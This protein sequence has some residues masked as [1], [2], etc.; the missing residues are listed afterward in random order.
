MER[1]HLIFPQ[2]K[3]MKAF[4]TKDYSEDKQLG[5]WQEIMSDVY[6]SLEIKRSQTR[7][8]RGKIRKYDIGPVSITTFDADEQRVFRTKPRIARDPEDAYVFVMPVRKDLYFNHNGRSGFVKPGGHVLVSTSDFYELSCPDGFVNWTVKIPGEELRQRNPCVDDYT[9]CRFPIDLP[10][11][12]FARQQVRSLAVTFGNAG[13]RNSAGLARNLIDTIALV[14]TTEMGSGDGAT[15]SQYLIRGRIMS[16]IRN[17]IGEFDLSP[18]M[19]AEANGISVSYL[20][21]LFRT[22]GMTVGEYIMA[23]RLQAAYERLAATSSRQTTVAE[24]AFSVGFRN[25][26]HF[27]RVFR[28]NYGVSPTSVRNSPF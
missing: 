19:I 15:K 26:S 4:S 11:S 17:N 28:E 24:V 18:R 27:S 9:G 14:V 12:H 13:P 10:M 16:Y 6:Y 1:E 25:L 23:Q 5:A 21:K 22:S 7:G 3:R 20:Y 2:V 8:L